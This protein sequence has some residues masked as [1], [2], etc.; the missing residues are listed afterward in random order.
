MSV[1]LRNGAPQAETAPYSTKVCAGVH[2]GVVVSTLYVWLDRVIVTLSALGARVSTAGVG[3]VRVG[4]ARACGGH[5]MEGERTRIYQSM[6]RQVVRPASSN[7]ACA[8]G[9]PSETLMMTGLMFLGMTSAR[10]QREN[11]FARMNN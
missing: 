11:A 8:V 1:L 2:M 6:I 4:A 3:A 7:P 5:G 9:L 10:Y